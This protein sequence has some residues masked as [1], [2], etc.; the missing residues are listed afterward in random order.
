MNAFGYGPDRFY[1]D[2]SVI[3]VKVFDFRV[4]SLNI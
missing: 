3:Y 4:I 1:T 2:K